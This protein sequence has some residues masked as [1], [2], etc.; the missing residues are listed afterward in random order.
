[1]SLPTNQNQLRDPLHSGGVNW[2][3]LL[4]EIQLHPRCTMV[5][6]SIQR[7]AQTLSHRACRLMWS[8]L[9]LYIIFLGQLI[10]SSKNLCIMLIKKKTS[11][12]FCINWIK[13]SEWTWVCGRLCPSPPK[14]KEKKR[15][16]YQWCYMGEWCTLGVVRLVEA[17][18]QAVH[19][20]SLAG[21]WKHTTSTV[22]YLPSSAS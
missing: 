8:W 16:M 21:A 15:D 17:F 3:N 2:N 9:H 7:P 6:G 11:P 5:Q 1:M 22:T 19:V 10:L 12:V 4:E 14:K 18:P 13:E 20:S